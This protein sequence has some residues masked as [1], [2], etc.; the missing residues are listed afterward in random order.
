LRSCLEL[1]VESLNM[2]LLPGPLGSILDYYAL[3]LRMDCRPSLKQ[4]YASNCGFVE[5]M[6][7]ECRGVEARGIRP[8]NANVLERSKMTN[9]SANGLCYY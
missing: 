1:R 8:E 5:R 2:G 9:A 6:Y 3:N 4:Y 7:L